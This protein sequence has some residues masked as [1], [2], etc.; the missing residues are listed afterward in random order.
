MTLGRMH[1]ICSSKYGQQVCISSEH[2]FHGLAGGIWP[3]FDHWQCKL[4]TTQAHRLDDFG[5]QLA[6][7]SN[8][9]P[10]ADLHPA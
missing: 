6:R 8:K 7:F 2:D 4:F 10:P 9:R 3:T 1:L 5:Q